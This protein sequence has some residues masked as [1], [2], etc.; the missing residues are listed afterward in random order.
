MDLNHHLRPRRI[1]PLLRV[2]CCGLLTS[3]VLGAAQAEDRAGL[4]AVVTVPALKG[5]VEPILPEGGTVT[6][7][8]KPGQ[9]EHGYE[10]TP[11]DLATLAKA[12]V[13]VL[14]G[15][16]LESR[17]ERALERKENSARRVVIFGDVLQLKQAEHDH[18]D[19][20]DKDGH[21][22]TDACDHGDHGDGWVDQHLWLDPTLVEKLVP[23]LR[24]AV[25]ESMVVRNEWNDDAATALESRTTKLLDRV[26]EVDATWQRELKPLQGSAIVTHHDAFSRP[27]ERYGLTI[28]AVIRPGA[29]SESSPK[30][31]ANAVQAIKKQ[32]VKAVFFEPQFSKQAA[33]RIASQ[34]GVRLASL[35]PLGDGDW[36]ALMR[37]NLD[38]L[39]KNLAKAKL[40]SESGS[41]SR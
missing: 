15:L 24:D 7:L 41:P 9:S 20:D 17:V 19:H 8:M 13:V 33:Q 40:P 10:F 18:H 23:A 1:H 39:T 37:S 5:L 29:G 21:E 3:F 11:Q 4:R 28:A 22:H 6:M 30:D 35:D 16:G 34:A 12:D 27:A 36:F 32:G 38:A 14:V 31:I 25:H 2:L 26:R